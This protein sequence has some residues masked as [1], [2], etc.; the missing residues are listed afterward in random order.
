MNNQNLH[1]PTAVYILDD[2]CSFNVAAK[3]P[4]SLV[5]VPFV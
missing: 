3:F 1:V 4:L 2:V 5:Q